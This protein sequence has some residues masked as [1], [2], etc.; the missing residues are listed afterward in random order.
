MRELYNQWLD[1]GKQTVTPAGNVRAPSRTEICEM[2][3]QAWSTIPEE[4]IANS[5]KNCGQ[6]KNGTPEEVTCMK[7]GRTAEG[8]LIEVKKFWNKSAEEF[9]NFSLDQGEVEPDENEDPFVLDESD[10]SDSE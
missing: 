4:M 3:A 6:T 9:E 5:F 8:A 7:T 2:V 10:N 1:S